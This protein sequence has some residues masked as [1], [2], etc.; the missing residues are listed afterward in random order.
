LLDA[1]NACAREPFAR[2]VWRVAVAGRDPLR[3][4]PSISRWCD[5]TFD[6]LYTALERDG[7]VAEVHAMLSLQPVFPSRMKWFTHKLA[8]AAERTLMLLDLA[9]VGRLS[10]DVARYGDRDYSRTQAIANAAYFLDFDGLVAPSARWDGLNAVLFTE[11]I[12]PENLTV[13][14]SA[15][16][17]I[18]WDAWRRRR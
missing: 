7:A 17:A 3:G 5:G 9:A 11:R 8:V 14:D 15:T 2:P 6:V 4:A 16:D 12:A 18:D 1:V 13:V 10:V